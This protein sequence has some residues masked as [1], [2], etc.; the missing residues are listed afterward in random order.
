M[1][2]LLLL[3]LLRATS[4]LMTTAEKK[5]SATKWLHNRNFN[6]IELFRRILFCSEHEI[7]NR[8]LNDGLYYCELR[9]RT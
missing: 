1:L 6:E 8:R 9:D 2:L 5:K 3:L 4:V 7:N